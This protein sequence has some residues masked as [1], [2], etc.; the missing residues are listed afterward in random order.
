M[1]GPEDLVRTADRALYRA[2]E[3]G[4]NRVLVASVDDTIALAEAAG[5]L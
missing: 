4:R 1:E 2:K 3:T 5:I